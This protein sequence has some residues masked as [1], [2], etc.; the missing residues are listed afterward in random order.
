MY[1]RCRSFWQRYTSCEFVI[2]IDDDEK[3]AWD[4]ENDCYND[5]EELFQ[6]LYSQ[7]YDI[8]I[9]LTAINH[10]EKLEGLKSE[11]ENM[12]KTISTKI[13]GEIL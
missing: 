4:Y 7:Y 5:L 12:K 3:C 13:F 2:V 6:A 1:L 9:S 8:A 10:K 11:L